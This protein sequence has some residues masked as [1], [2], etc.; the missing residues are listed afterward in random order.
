MKTKP[1]E[2]CTIEKYNISNLKKNLWIDSIAE[3]G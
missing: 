1:Q 3:W 2:I